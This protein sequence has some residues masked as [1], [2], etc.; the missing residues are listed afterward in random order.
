MPY[1]VPTA[2]QANQFWT[3]GYVLIEGAATPEETRRAHAG[4]MGP[5]PD[6]L[7]LPD[8]YA[9]HGARTKP[10]NADGNH[11][12]H[13]PELIPLLVSERLY[14]AAVDIFGHEL[15]AVGDGSVGITFKVS[16]GPTLSQRLHLDMHRS[17]VINE[18]TLR[19]KVGIGGCYYLSNV[20][21]GGAGTYVIPGGRVS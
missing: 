8:H 4:I 16:G 13:I 3:D 18:T 15:L 5:L 2:D 6:D 17:D 21:A 19:L 14:H 10:H 7:Y 11:S 1:G 9:S 12:Y 20:E